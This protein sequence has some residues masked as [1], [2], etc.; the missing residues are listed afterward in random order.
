M[1]ALHILQ[2]A[3]SVIMLLT[4]VMAHAKTATIAP[5]PGQKALRGVYFDPDC[6][7]V[8]LNINDAGKQE[9]TATIT[10]MLDVPEGQ[11]L[12]FQKKNKVALLPG[13]KFAFPV[14]L[15]TG[16]QQ[17]HFALADYKGIVKESF[18][19]LTMIDIKSVKEIMTRK[20]VFN[21]SMGASLI[22]YFQTGF[23]NITQYAVTPKF[24]MT[25]RLG[26]SRFDLGSS[27]FINAY[28]IN[29]AGG[30]MFRTI[31]ANAR[32]G[33]IMPWIDHPWRM[34][35]Y[36]G[37]Y[38]T[39][40]LTSPTQFGY[41]SMVYPHLFPTLSRA[42]TER[43]FIGTYFKFTPMGSGISFSIT[44]RELAGGISWRHTL[45][46]SHPLSVSLDYSNQTMKDGKVIF[47]MTSVS[48][49][50]GYDL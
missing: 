50:A 28:A 40:M 37:G 13:F 26:D 18:Y 33:F 4:T 3:L 12:V 23:K 35:F 24:T 38:Y 48:L 14:V 19:T 2:A 43:D 34:I 7:E 15:P 49:G 41:R 32:L 46:N 17:I 21:V 16:S 47:K 11:M 10:G 9:I 31:G 36:A 5:T 42:I 22:T 45:S 20:L 1:K 8:V 39:T 30:N 27:A 29:P 25:Y 44:D 6:C